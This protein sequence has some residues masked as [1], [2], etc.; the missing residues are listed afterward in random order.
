MNSQFSDLYE[1]SFVMPVSGLFADLDTGHGTVRLPDEF[2]AT[3]A[4]VQLALLADWQRGLVQAQ[5]RAFEQL[6]AEIQARNCFA[7]AEELARQFAQACR[8]LGQ[9]WPPEFAARL[10]PRNRLAADNDDA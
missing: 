9:A 4:Q 5:L 10:Q 7:T 6:Y 2:G 1:D 8:E 3:P